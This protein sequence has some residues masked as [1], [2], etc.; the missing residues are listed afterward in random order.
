MEVGLEHQSRVIWPGE[1]ESEV[2]SQFWNDAWALW[3]RHGGINGG[4]MDL[5]IYQE[6]RP[7][8]TSFKVQLEP[9]RRLSRF[10]MD[11]ARG[12]Q[13]SKNW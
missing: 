1:F 10:E 9:E 12:N 11:I 8:I 5:R 2:I 3:H 7:R 4:F 6:L 13:F